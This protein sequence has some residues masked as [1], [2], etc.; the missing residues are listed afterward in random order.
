MDD[1]DNFVCAC[2]LYL[3]G[4]KTVFALLACMASWLSSFCLCAAQHLLPGFQTLTVKV[5]LPA[6]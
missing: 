2:L 4:S 5:A 1:S 3:Y 6:R